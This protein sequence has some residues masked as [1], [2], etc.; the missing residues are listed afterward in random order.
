[1]FFII[2]SKLSLDHFELGCLK[3]YLRAHQPAHARW[4]SN[5]QS[6]TLMSPFGLQ[7]SHI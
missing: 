4:D 1:M 5:L 7:R 6:L 3:K 2:T